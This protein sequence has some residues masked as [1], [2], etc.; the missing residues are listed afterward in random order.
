MPSRPLRAL[1]LGLAS[2]AG[3]ASLGFH[4]AAAGPAPVEVSVSVA[5]DR[6]GATI[7]PEIY[8]QFVEHL[9]EGVYGG[10]WVGE[11]S[12]I[13]NTRGIRNDVLGALKALQVPLMRWPGGCF[14]DEYHWREGI[15]PRDRRPSRP[16]NSWGGLETNAFGTH[17]F[18]D[19]AEL[20]GART[21]VNANL[22]S[23]TPQEM[24][25]WLEYMISDSASTLANERRANGRAAPFPLHWYAIGNES[26]GCGGNMRVEYYADLYKH[27][28]TFVRSPAERPVKKIAVGPTND[29]YGWTEV[30]MKQAAGQMDA[31]SLH[32]YTLP[33]GSWDKKGPAVG[34]GEAEWA[35]TLKQTLRMDEFVR[36]HVAIMD[37]HDP[38]KKVALAV[39]EWGTWYDATPGKPALWQQNSQR[40]AIVAAINLNIF[41]HH[42]DRVRMA[43]IA[44]MV[45][46][47]QAMILTEGDRMVLTPT[48]HVFALYRPFQGA[49]SLPVAVQA[50]EYRHGDTAL[51]RVHASAARGKDGALYVAFA[52]LSPTEPARLKLA[53]AG[54]GEGVV[55]GSVL[56][57]PAMDTVNTFDAPRQVEPRPYPTGRLRAGA[58]AGDLPA[59]SVVVLRV[60]PR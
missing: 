32:Y 50:P 49:T 16:N 34:F 14:A 37:K 36:G 12:S 41:H 20:V 35:A 17:E 29:W 18:F 11:D 10:L 24:T 60:A 33:T 8:G 28:A 27:W 15:G 46:V 7:Q 58:F 6:P 51:P 39:D 2:L 31:L 57:A 48:Y 52:N 38:Q 43:N 1:A 55:T 22:G 30:M 21:Y 19:L 47:L 3:A 9:G 5:A 54:G 13:P 59:R 4:A 45:N 26:W 56:T 25:D 40:D 53:V 42:A 23:G 44:Q